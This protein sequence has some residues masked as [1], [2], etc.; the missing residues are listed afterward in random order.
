VS[1]QSADSAATSAFERMGGVS[2]F[3]TADWMRNRGV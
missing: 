3:N 2:F 1:S